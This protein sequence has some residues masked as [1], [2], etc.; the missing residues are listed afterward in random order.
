MGN[1]I[2]E[3]TKPGCRKNI[4]TMSVR[5]YIGLCGVGQ[6]TEPVSCTADVKKGAHFIMHPFIF[7]AP[8]TI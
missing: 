1:T 4:K 7:G 5:A 6:A 2:R 8:E 3:E